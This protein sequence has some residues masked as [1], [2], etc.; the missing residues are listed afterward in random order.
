MAASINDLFNEPTTTTRPNPATTTAVKTNGASSVTVDSTDGWATATAVHFTMYEVDADNEKVANTQ[1]DYKGIV[2][3]STT[4]NNLVVTAGTDREFPI[5]SKVICAPTAAWGDD[6]VEG[7]LVSHDQDGTLKAGAVDATAVLADDVVTRAKINDADQ[8][9]IAGSYA[10][11][12]Y[13]VNGKIVTSVASNDLTVAIKTLAGTDPSSTDPVHV[14]IGNTVR[15]ITSALSVT[16][17]DG[18]NWFNSGSASLATNEIDY[19]VY[20]GYNAT[21]GVV[22]GFARIPYARTYGDFSTTTTNDRYCAISTITNAASSDEYENIGR[23]NAILSATASFNWSIPAT[24]VIIS[25]PI[26]ETRLLTYSPQPTNITLGNGTTTG[27]YRIND[28]G[29][30]VHNKFTLGSTSSITGS[31]PTFTLPITA[32]TTTSTSSGKGLIIYNDNGVANYY[33]KI[34]VSSAATTYALTA[35]TASGTYTTEVGV[36]ST[37][38]FTFG[39]TDSVTS[40]FDCEI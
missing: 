39:N 24:S 6:L 14:R 22:I 20:L 15:T 37:V 17:N 26:F 1:V 23:F 4:I 13:M 16:K 25:R 12:G 35:E 11:Q 30:D 36:S 7:L 18:T 34:F 27:K 38:P 8:I 28:R 32:A 3:S 21:D 19:F 2:N 33:G 31:F 5:G 40:E 29:L 9:G 10:P